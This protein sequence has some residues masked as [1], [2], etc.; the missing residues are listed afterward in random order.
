[1]IKLFKNLVQG[2]LGNYSEVSVRELTQKYGDFLF[3]EEMI[4]SGYRLIRDALLF[5]NYRIIFVDKQ[6]ATGKKVAYHSIYLDGIVDVTV[7]TAG[8]GVDDSEIEITFLENVYQ[9]PHDEVL[10]TVK[11]EFPKSLDILPL[12][13][14]LGNLVLENRSRINR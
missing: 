14:Y 1:M 6:G 9:K 10:K 8:F 4:N 11:F 2:A 12:Y 5:T 3:E 13:R 7:E